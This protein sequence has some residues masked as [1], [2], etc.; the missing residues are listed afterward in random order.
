MRERGGASFHDSKTNVGA[1]EKS[2]CSFAGG[3]VLLLGGYDKGG[4]FAV[5]RPLVAERVA[6]LVCFGAAGADVARQLEGAAECE[7]VPG[8]SAAVA[9]AVRTARPG[10]SIVL[11][12]GCASFDEFTDYA[13][14]GRRF[15]AAVEAL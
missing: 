15:R 11:A 9:A 7:V 3:V 5:L 12:P 4:D 1:V 8:L 6:R 13:D 14:R 2:L 10:Q